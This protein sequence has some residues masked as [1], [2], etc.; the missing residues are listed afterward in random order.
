MP[1]ASILI[2]DDEEGITRLCQRLLERAN[3]K[4]KAIIDP[5]EGVTALRQEQFDLLLV[6]IRMPGM[7]GFEVIAEG[8]KIQPDIAVVIMTGFG[9]LETAIRALRQG[10]DG[11]IL[12]PF[13]EGGEL[14]NTVREA[15]K[16]RQHKQEV[17]RLRTI[18]PLLDISESLFS[19]TRFEALLDLVLNAICGHLKCSHAAIYQRKAGD[20]FL[21]LIKRIGNA[22]PEEHSRASAGLVGRADHWKIP[23][24]INLDSPGDS[25]FQTILRE[26]RFGA[27]ICTPV[28]RGETSLVFMAGR[29]I[30]E[31]GFQLIDLELFGLLARQADVAFENAHLYGELRENVRQIEESQRALIQAEKMAAV[32]RLTA[33]IAHE[34]NN[35]LQAVRNCLHLAGRKELAD[36]ER[37]N[38]QHL[39]EEE[40]DRLMSTVQRMLDFYRPGA[41]DRKPTDITELLQRVLSLLEKQ[42]SDREIIVR[43]KIEKN[44]P[45]VNVVSNQIQQVFFNLILNAME[46]MGKGGNLSVV[47]GKNQENVEISFVDDG[48]GVPKHLRDRIFE[49]FVS[50]SEDGTGLGLSVSYGILTAHGGSLELLSENNKGACFKVVIPIKE[51]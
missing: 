32:G 18:R 17:A 24:L 14:V 44:L 39:A 15:L 5:I 48:P 21:Y 4:V 28:E 13:E 23:I 30:G 22:L 25:E 36:E 35:P 31:P 34:V 12:K 45:P 37:E 9:T 50:L 27:V 43:T 20:N 11:L 26:Y 33:S 46:A 3:Y 51:A 40:L 47:A 16:E 29:E 42:L 41:L 1:E 38:Y 2:I 8:R 10:A 6:D 49:P 19:E 7:D